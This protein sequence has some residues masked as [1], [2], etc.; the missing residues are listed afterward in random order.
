LSIPDVGPVAKYGVT[1]QPRGGYI[2]P[3]FGAVGDSQYIKEK[4]ILKQQQ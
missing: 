3:F 4:H 2:S 1:V